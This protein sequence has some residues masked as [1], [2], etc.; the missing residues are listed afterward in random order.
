M[1]PVAAPVAL[2]YDRCASRSVRHLEMR[3]LGCDTYIDRMGWTMAGR[4]V[5]LGEDALTEWRPKLDALLD[6]MREAAAQREVLCLV[7]TWERLA[8]DAEY[9]MSLR[10]R[11]VEAGGWTETTFGESDR[12][13]RM[14]LAGR[15]P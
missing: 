8:A 1:T 9:R 14:L 3:L 15:R 13:G 11:V 6:A 12:R 2:V 4:W 5:D 10:K 7:H